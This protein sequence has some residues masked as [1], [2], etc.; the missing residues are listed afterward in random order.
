M[1]TV[2]KIYKTT[3]TNTYADIDEWIAEHGPCGIQN[4]VYVLDGDMT[5][6]SPQ[7]V[8][9][10]CSYENEEKYLAHKEEPGTNPDGE[11]VQVGEDE[12][13]IS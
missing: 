2:A 6:E 13:T 7:S 9:V 10:V 5:L 8:K 1:Y 4:F 11:S 3:N 12:V